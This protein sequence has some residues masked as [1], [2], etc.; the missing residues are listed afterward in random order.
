[1][2]RSK[3][4]QYLRIGLS[5]AGVRASDEVC[6]LIIETQKGIAKK[7][8]K[9]SISDAVDTKYRVQKRHAKQNH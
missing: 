5:L 1:M 2:N 6:D 3:E 4:I 8:G 9:Y 7:K